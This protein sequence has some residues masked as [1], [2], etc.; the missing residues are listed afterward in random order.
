M[1]LAEMLQRL[2]DRTPEPGPLYWVESR[3]MCATCREFEVMEQGDTCEHCQ[4]E[5]AQGYQVMSL[6]GRCANGFEMDHG[7]RNHAVTLGE[8]SAR[9]GAKPGR[10][11]VGWS[12]EV[13]KTVT[14]PRCV[15]KI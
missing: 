10:R 4:K 12:R 5:T 8:Y 3:P 13:G 6:A 9:C 1:S 15:K 11:S 2:A 14:C 7:T